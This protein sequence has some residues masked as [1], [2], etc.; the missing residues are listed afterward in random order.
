MTITIYVWYSDTSRNNATRICFTNS[1]N[2]VLLGANQRL[3]IY[4]HGH[5]SSEVTLHGW[6][7]TE[8]VI[9]TLLE[10]IKAYLGKRELREKHYTGCMFL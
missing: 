10:L 6:C 1:A 9:Y 7:F 4:F 2:Y 3:Q 5:F 8:R